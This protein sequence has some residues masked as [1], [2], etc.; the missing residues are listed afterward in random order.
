LDDVG[1]AFGWPARQP[2][3]FRR[4]ALMGLLFVVPI[5]GWVATTGWMLATLDNLRSGR[6]MLA[7]IGLHLGRGWRLVLV[8]LV[9][10]LVVD[11]LAAAAAVPGFLIAN[12]LHDTLGALGGIFLV[13]AG[14][15]IEVLGVVAVST[16]LLPAIISA[17]DAGGVRSG[18]HLPRI[19]TTLHAKPQ[20]AIVS[21]LLLLL[22]YA[23][24]SAGA[25]ACGIG[26]FVTIGYSLPVMAAIFNRYEQV[27]G[28]PLSR[29]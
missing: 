18:L 10:G 22:V 29:A 21:A 6:R 3:W 27:I 5:L 12:A 20:P 11:A 9:Y 16:L 13:I 8:L 24:Q 7:P 23:F 14:C 19:I 25:L 4:C 28:A 26:I 2:G 17:T 1:E 15:A